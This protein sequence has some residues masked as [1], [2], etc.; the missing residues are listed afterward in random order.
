MQKYLPED[1]KDKQLLIMLDKEER[2]TVCADVCVGTVMGIRLVP[3]F[4]NSNVYGA[5]CFDFLLEKNSGN[6]D[7]ICDVQYDS[8]FYFEFL[9]TIEKHF[10]KPIPKREITLTAEE[11]GKI[12]GAYCHHPDI[13]AH[14]PEQYSWKRSPNNQDYPRWNESETLG[15]NL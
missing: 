2:K 8:K 13:A 14:H 3:N 11:I 6:V 7:F 9:P 1:N 12:I 10:P 5:K 15:L 4:W